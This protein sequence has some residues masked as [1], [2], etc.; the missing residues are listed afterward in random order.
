MKYVQGEIIQRKMSGEIPWGEIFR[1]NREK[2]G[3]VIVQRGTIRGN[4]SEVFVF[5]G[6]I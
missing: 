3:G 4:C 1:M 6:V 5:G 2:G